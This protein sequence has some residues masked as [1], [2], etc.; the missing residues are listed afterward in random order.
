V[1]IKLIRMVAPPAPACFAD[2]LA[3]AEYLA[4]AMEIKSEATKPFKQAIYQ[5]SFNWCKDCTRE[6]RRQMVAEHRCNPP[7]IA[8]PVL[9]KETA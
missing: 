8:R 5:P 6:H 1:D 9:A 3:W 2:R 4:S 7:V